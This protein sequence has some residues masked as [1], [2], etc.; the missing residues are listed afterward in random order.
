MSNRSGSGRRVRAPS[1]SRGDAM[2]LVVDDDAPSVATLLERVPEGICTVVA[3]SCREAV[4]RVDSC[5][6]FHGLAV[7]VRLHDRFGFDVLEHWLTKFPDAPAVVI[8]EHAD[9]AAVAEYACERSCRL[10]AKPFGR[11][12]FQAFA[13]DVDAFR[14]G[15][16]RSIAPKFMAFKRRHAL[17]TP[18]AELFASYIRRDPRDEVLQRL[19]ITASTLKTRTEQ[20]C[21]RV[22]ARN[23]DVA[24]RLMLRG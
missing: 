2:L 5:D 21:T 13:S 8:T 9:S 7:C 6:G 20:L 22:G 3:T 18:R 23:I 17:S 19:N 14:W 12:P 10:L 1:R 11:A 24:Y 15:V 4:E 16:S